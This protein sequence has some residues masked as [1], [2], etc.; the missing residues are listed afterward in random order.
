[1]EIINFWISI[2]AI[3][4]DLT[5]IMSIMQEIVWVFFQTKKMIVIHSP[6]SFIGFGGGYLRGNVR[7]PRGQWCNMLFARQRSKASQ[8]HG[9]YFGS[10]K[11]L[12]YT[13]DSLRFY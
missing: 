2:T 11:D 8:R 12:V 1:M 3:V 4:R 6:D 9:I 13:R 5:F 10:L 7:I